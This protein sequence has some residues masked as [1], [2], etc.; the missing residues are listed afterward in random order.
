MRLEAALCIKAKNL[1]KGVLQGL[2][3]KA[4]IPAPIQAHNIKIFDKQMIGGDLR[5][6]AAGKANAQNPPFGPHSAKSGLK[7]RAAD[8]IIKHINTAKVAQL[9]A[10]IGVSASIT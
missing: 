4:Q 3:I 6:G 9:V 7:P 5:N 10:Q 8:R 2:W 1:L